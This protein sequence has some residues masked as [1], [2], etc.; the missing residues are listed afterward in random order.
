MEQNNFL[1]TYLRD[2]KDITPNDT[3]EL[4]KRGR[5]EALFRA[6]ADKLKQKNEFFPKI[7]IEQDRKSVV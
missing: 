3:K 7:H 4:S 2:I 1:M 5:L 6:I